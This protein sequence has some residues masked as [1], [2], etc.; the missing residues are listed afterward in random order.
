MDAWVASL[1]RTEGGIQAAASVRQLTNA[2][3]AARDA[4]AGVEEALAKEQNQPDNQVL[5]QVLPRFSRTVRS[6]V[7]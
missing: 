2:R 7:I 4:L 5:D 3:Q 1:Q 6:C